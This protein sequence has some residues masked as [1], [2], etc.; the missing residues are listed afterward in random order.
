M[1]LE[2]HIQ[3]AGTVIAQSDRD[4]WD[5][6]V[7]V[8]SRRPKLLAPG[9]YTV[10][11]GFRFLLVSVL[12]LI[13]GV[14]VFLFLLLLIVF[15]FFFSVGLTAASPLLV[16]IPLMFI[17]VAG[18]CSLTGLVMCLAVPKQAGVRSAAALMLICFVTGL[19]CV[20]AFVV[21][22]MM[23]AA[24]ILNAPRFLKPDA[25]PPIGAFL[26]TLANLFLAT[27]LR[28]SAKVLSV[29]DVRGKCDGVLLISLLLL[30]AGV[31]ATSILILNGVFGF[32]AWTP[33]WEAAAML[34]AA[35][36]LCG[37]V[38]LVFLYRTI[39][40]R[41]IEVIDGKV[42]PTSGDDRE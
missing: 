23:I 6:R 27:F 12:A 14:A 24:G 7:D 10:G 21:L 41:M 3:E 35:A 28:D 8:K 34:L 17:V 13:L 36:W 40:L 11:A 42:L 4:D 30:V 29:N 26:L 19:L 33:D 20:A 15:R 31:G 39:I 18:L 9:W 22:R 32:I 5:V 16:T 2:S 25:F 1:N 38:S 37:G